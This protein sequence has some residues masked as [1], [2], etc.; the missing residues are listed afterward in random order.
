MSSLQQWSVKSLQTVTARTGKSGGRC[1][2]PMRKNRSRPSLETLE[3]RAVPTVLFAPHFAGTTEY[4]PAGTTISQEHAASLSSPS[5]VLIFSGSYW[6]STTGASN[7]QALTTA[8]QGIISSGYL[9]DL[10]QYGS[11]GKAI[12]YG[13]FQD[14]ATPT[15]SGNTPSGATLLSYIQSEIKIH[16]KSVPSG[17]NV[18]YMVVND[19]NDSNKSFSTYGFN[20]YDGKTLH[21]AY[22]GA[23]NGS[24]GS[25]DQNGFTQVYSHE[26]AESMTPAVHI[27][28]PG[29]LNAGYQIADNEPESFGSGYTYRLPNGVLVQAYWSQKDG[30]WAV[31][32]GNSQNF[33]LSWATTNFNNTYNL[34]VNGDQ[35]GTNYNDNITIDR[36]ANGCPGTRVIENGQT[37]SFD[38]GVIKSISINTY[39][40]YDTVN[41]KS[42]ESG[43]TVNVDSTST[44]SFDDII[45]GSSG[46]LSSIQGPV[47]VSNSSGR[48]WLQ[49]NDSADS[50]RNITITSSS[51]VFQG[52]ATINYTPYAGP[53]GGSV[54]GVMGLEI[55]DPY[56]ANQINVLSVPTYMPITI[57]GNFLDNL[58]GPAASKVGLNRYGYLYH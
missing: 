39:G 50:P 27:N 7:Q 35:L 56:G 57:E 53:S 20:S 46:S 25:L 44:T 19:P 52:V 4:A 30:A 51:V 18:L 49:I 54:H 3:A 43:Q 23:V 42:V 9:S 28:D 5:I 38:P 13:S 48:S 40:G 45:V 8:V 33:F 29:N 17:S 16:P 11:D 55:D 34:Q 15:L 10:S 14:N 1:S 36:A 21:T 58:F 6:T 47:N 26:L 31:P 32:D 12:Y 24:S 37:A 41:I 22:V 2:A